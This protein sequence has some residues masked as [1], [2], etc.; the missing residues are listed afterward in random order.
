MIYRLNLLNTSLEELSN[1]DADQEFKCLYSPDIDVDPSRFDTVNTVSNTSPTQKRVQL[2][3]LVYD[4]EE[5]SQQPIDV[6]LSSSDKPVD[7]VTGYFRNKLQY[8][9]PDMSSYE[10]DMI[11]N[12]Y[13]NEYAL[14][15]CGSREIMIGEQNCLTS[16]RV[17][18]S[19]LIY[20]A[21]ILISTCNLVHSEVFV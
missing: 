17:T 1:S 5:P 14:R 8:S 13:R 4:L 21:S 20:E 2:N 7:V 6:I 3:L 12:S 19:L 16:Y 18:M 10:L 11:L 9:A 15:V